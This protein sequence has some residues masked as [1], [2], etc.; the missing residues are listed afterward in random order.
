MTDKITKIVEEG[1][2]TEGTPQ[3]YVKGNWKQLTWINPK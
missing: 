1:R 2:T 3:D